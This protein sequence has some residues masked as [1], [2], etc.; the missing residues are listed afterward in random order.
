MRFWK[1]IL[2]FNYYAL[3]GKI[4]KKREQERQG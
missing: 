3:M 4:F 2:Y 1:M